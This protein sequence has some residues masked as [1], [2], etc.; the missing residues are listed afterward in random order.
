MLEELRRLEE[1]DVVVGFGPLD[2]LRLAVDGLADAR[3]MAELQIA[4]RRHGKATAE[5]FA[6]VVAKLEASDE[7]AQHMLP[8]VEAILLRH[9]VST[10]LLQINLRAVSSRSSRLRRLSQR[11]W[12]QLLKASHPR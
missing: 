8:I 2:E 10:Y 7:L 6:F 9:I 4:H 5:V 3:E 12:R 11:S 1:D